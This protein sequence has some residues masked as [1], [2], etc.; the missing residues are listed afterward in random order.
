MWTA[1]MDREVIM[2]SEIRQRE[3]DKYYMTSP[4]CLTKEN[5]ITPSN[6]DQI[7]GYQNWEVEGDRKG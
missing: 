4:I 7:C 6:R 3:K 1:W 5:R 2:L